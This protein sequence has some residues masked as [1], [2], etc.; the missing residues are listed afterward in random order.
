MFVGWTKCISDGQNEYRMVIMYIESHNVHRMVTMYIDR[1]VIMFIGWTVL[2]RMVKMYI[3]WSKRAS[4]GHNDYQVVTLKVHAWCLTQYPRR[5][6]NY[7]YVWWYPCKSFFS[8]CRMPGFDFLYG[9]FSETHVLVVKK[10]G[11]KHN[12]AELNP[13]IRREELTL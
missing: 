4:N 10:P 11:V 13:G 2:Y 8:P 7:E 6:N 9:A 5:L 12:C 3:G 1:M